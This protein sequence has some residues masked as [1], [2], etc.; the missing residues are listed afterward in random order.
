MSVKIVQ[1]FALFLL[2]N[3]LIASN[4]NPVELGKVDWLRNFDKGI[5]LSA[6]QQKPIFLL[7]QEVPGCSTCRNYGQNV[8]SHPLI[9]EAIESLFVPVAIF[10]NKRGKDAEV[11]RFYGEP[12]W[13]NPVVRIVNNQKQNLVKRVNGNYTQ[14]G[15][16]QAMVQALQAV[17]LDVPNYLL[18]LEQELLADKVGVA[19]T[20]FSMY[21]FWTGE[22]EIGKM[23]GVLETQAG[24]MNGREVVQ[25][26][27]DPE[28]IAFD[29]LLVG[30]NRASCAD[31]VFTND[32][33][34]IES[35]KELLG[36]GKTQKPGKFRQDKDP[37]YY[38]GR[39]IYRF[40]P[41]TQLQAA[42]VNSHIGQGRIPN[43]FLS[44]RQLNLLQTVESNPNK[45]WEDAINR[46]IEDAWENIA[47]IR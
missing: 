31:Y 42:K 1:V 10:N 18:L 47:S 23:D 35:S 16:V 15:I 43:E 36:K 41:M 40:I 34:Q 39:T 27:Y 14:L 25:V 24:Y 29:E 3:V 21:C 33:Q 12:S 26:K 46:D 45:R 20:T 22:K 2:T 13:N 7:F 11:L 4:G 5:E 30:A 44:P 9:V 8:L 17:S 19:T 38:L 6:E 37:K 32:G 28:I